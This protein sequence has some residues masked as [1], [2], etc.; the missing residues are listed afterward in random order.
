MAGVILIYS[1]KDQNF[2]LQ[3]PGSE[4]SRTGPNGPQGPSGTILNYVDR[5]PNDGSFLRAVGSTTIENRASFVSPGS[6]AL[7]TV[8]VW[9][10]IAPGV[11]DSRVFTFR[12]NGVNTALSVTI[13]G[14]STTGTDLVNSVAV[15]PGDLISLLHT[16]IGNPNNTGLSVS[17]ILN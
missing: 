8:Y 9:V 14:A 5:N 17:A 1:L 12:L 16:E 3:G 10:S 4:T 11:G 2:L 6:Y 15:T 7:S 13:S